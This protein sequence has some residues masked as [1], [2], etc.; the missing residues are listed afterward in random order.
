MAGAEADPPHHGAAPVGGGRHLVVVHEG[1]P[2]HFPNEIRKLKAQCPQ[3]T[4]WWSLRPLTVT[5]DDGGHCLN[6]G[7]DHAGQSKVADAA[8][9]PSV[10]SRYRGDVRTDIIHETLSHFVEKAHLLHAPA[11]PDPLGSRSSSPSCS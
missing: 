2:V 8:A 5:V 1:M 10:H 9:R 3:E 7:E 4:N 6:H 11:R